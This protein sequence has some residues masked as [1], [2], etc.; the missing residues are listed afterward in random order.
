MISFQGI[1]DNFSTLMPPIVTF[2]VIVAGAMYILRHP[3]KLWVRSR[4]CFLYC[5]LLLPRQGGFSPGLSMWWLILCNLS[6]KL[7]ASLKHFDRV[8]SKVLMAFLGNAWLWARSASCWKRVGQISVGRFY[9]S[10][11]L[12]GDATGR[13]DIKLFQW[14]RREVGGRA[15][16]PAT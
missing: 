13:S 10:V 11:W 3:E 9:L 15:A 12:N 14:H 5:L 8:F 1:W 4:L 6:P 16:F 2:A 7:T